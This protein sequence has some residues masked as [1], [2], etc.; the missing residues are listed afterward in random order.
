[1]GSVSNKKRP[2]APTPYLKLMYTFVEG[3][4]VVGFGPPPAPP[5][6]HGLRY[7]LRWS[8]VARMKPRPAVVTWVLL[9]EVDQE[10]GVR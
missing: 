4:G 10:E 2:R 8:R 3:G 9:L 6:R 1:M 5:R 7:P